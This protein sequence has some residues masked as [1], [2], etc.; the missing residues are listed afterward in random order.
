M[1]TIVIL[2][3]LLPILAI[4]VGAAFEK[5][6]I[7]FLTPIS[8]VFLKASTNSYNDFL[9]QS[10]MYFCPENKNNPFTQAVKIEMSETIFLYGLIANKVDPDNYIVYIPTSP[11][12]TS[13]F[14]INVPKSK[15]TLLELSPEDII[16]LT[17]TCGAFTSINLH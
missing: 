1:T 14:I 13:G 6:K 16:K 15:V 12:P 9:V 4:L 11:N 3:L 7:P 5:K 10:S 8:K 2:L 17:I